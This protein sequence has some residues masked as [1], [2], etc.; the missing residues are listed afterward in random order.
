M[1]NSLLNLVFILPTYWTLATLNA[2]AG[3]VIIDDTHERIS[4]VNIWNRGLFFEDTSA[5]LTIEDL[6]TGQYDDK[7]KNGKDYQNTFGFTRSAFW[8]K[9][10]IDKKSVHTPSYLVINRVA[11]YEAVLYSEYPDG[12]IQIDSLGVNI[13]FKSRPFLSSYCVKPIIFKDNEESRSFYL[14]LR[15]ATSMFLPIYL[16]T[17]VSYQQ[18]MSNI[19]L[20]N[21]IYIGTLL[22]VIFYNI[23]SYLLRNNSVYLFYLFYV[24]CL[25]LYQGLFNTG[26]GFEY[27]WSD[28]PTIN[29]HGVVFSSMLAISMTIF[30][31][32]FLNI[33]RRSTAHRI[34]L[35]FV[36]LFIIT[37]VLNLL[38][39]TY[40]TSKHI[41]WVT[42][43][44][45]LFLIYLGIKSYKAGNSISRLYL[46]GWGSFLFFYI[47]FALWLN[48]FIGAS[49]LGHRALFIGSFLE[50]VFWFSAIADKIAISKKMQ[51]EEETKMR[52]EIARDFHDELGNRAARL[53]NQVG[54]Y[55]LNKKIDQSVYSDLNEHAQSILQGARDFIWSLDPQNETL[56]NLILHLKDFGEKI[57]TEGGINFS[58]HRYYTKD[59]TFPLGHS[60]QINLIF[61]EAMT[62]VFKHARATETSFTLEETNGLL[63]ITLTDNGVGLSKSIIENSERGLSN[64]KVRANR[65]GAHL[66]IES[67]TSSG[68]S[69]KLV[70]KKI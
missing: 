59:H 19:S 66:Q 16:D 35:L 40:F 22:I 5:A 44:T 49:A 28:Y 53:I 64:M 23:A 68:T 47:L 51:V 65:I 61:K 38:G 32:H 17:D 18:K 56:T 67:S 37:I 15:T 25:L 3:P 57:F 24:I 12:S 58:F 46:I 21:G 70:L 48:G 2:I 45:F 8:V 1:K 50:M 29:T 20:F 34:G 7:F 33:T 13:P 26:V 54:L 62:N 14:R 10:S 11:L 69:I 36:L 30:S 39:Y 43:P 55:S 42:I 31:L 9:F 41:F 27:V 6:R 60:R 63:S 4:S 52:R